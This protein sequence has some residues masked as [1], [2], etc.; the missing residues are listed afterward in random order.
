[1][2]TSI[3]DGVIVLA[4]AVLLFF[5][6]KSIRKNGTCTSDC[7]T[8]HGVCSAPKGKT[9]DFVKAYR[10]DHPKNTSVL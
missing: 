1:M 6:W 8:C 9:P 5:A 3:A 2:M 4:V 10:K 7:S